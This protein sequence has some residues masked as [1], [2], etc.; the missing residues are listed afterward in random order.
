MSIYLKIML[1]QTLLSW[2]IV[3]RTHRQNRINAG[4]IKIL[5]CVNNIAGI[6]SAN[7]KYD[8]QAFVIDL[9]CKIKHSAFFI[10]G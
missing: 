4:K 10:F 8:W 7:T 5:K 2:F 1:V 6:V 9:N 3:I